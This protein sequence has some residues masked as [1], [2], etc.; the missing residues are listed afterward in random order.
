MVREAVVNAVMHRNY[1]HQQ[2]VQLLRY[3]NRL[4]VQNPGYSLKTLENL[5]EPGSQWRNPVI[6]SV[7]HEMGLASP[8]L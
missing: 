4:E 1:Q 8:Y 5:G 2:P 3:S 7:L 6:A